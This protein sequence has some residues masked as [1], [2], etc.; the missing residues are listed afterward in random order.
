M[1]WIESLYER[2][3]F[4][5]QFSYWMMN[6]TKKAYKLTPCLLLKETKW[7]S[8]VCGVWSMYQRQ[9][10][11][12]PHTSQAS[13]LALTYSFV[14]THTHPHTDTHVNKLYS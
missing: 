13:Y 1:K 12:E 9:R 8:V 6:G 3:Y 10:E 14:Y 2:R 11:K 5:I 4:F 7:K